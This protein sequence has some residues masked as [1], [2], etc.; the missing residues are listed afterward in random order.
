MFQL[1]EKNIVTFVKNQL[2]M[3]NR[4]LTQDAESVDG[5]GEDEEVMNDEEREQKRGS[6]EAFL[7]MAVHFLKGMNHKELADDLQRSKRV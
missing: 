4:I 7:K 3:F 6:S 5:L 1:L 2:K